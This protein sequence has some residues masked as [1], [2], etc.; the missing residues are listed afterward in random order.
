MPI[1]TSSSTA[2]ARNA[3]PASTLTW[4]AIATLLELPAAPDRDLTKVQVFDGPGGLVCR[5]VPE[6]D[7]GSMAL[8]AAV[9]L[10]LHVDDV[11]GDAVGTLLGMQA[12]LLASGRWFL[13]MDDEGVLQLTALLPAAS[14]AEV[15]GCLCE[16]QLAAWATLRALLRPEAS[17][18]SAGLDAATERTARNPER[19]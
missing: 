10:G 9:R 3:D 7:A 8:R 1:T 2:R 5:L 4:S 13:G 12:T 14:A 11:P 17:P 19:S 6:H 15:A 16:G 18:P